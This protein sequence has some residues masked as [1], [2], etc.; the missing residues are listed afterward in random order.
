VGVAEVARAWTK[1]LDVLE[2][3]GFA[4]RAMTR[5]GASTEDLDRVIQVSGIALPDDMRALYRLSNGQ[6]E[7]WPRRQID[8]GVTTDLFPMYTFLSTEQA[9]TEWQGWKAIFDQEGPSGMADHAEFVIVPEPER[10]AKE[11]WHPGWWPLARDG[12]GNLLA[13]D[14]VPPPS[15]R[16]GQIIV[17]GSDEDVRR[18]FAPGIVA[19]LD[20]LSAAALEMHQRSGQV[21]WDIPALR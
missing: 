8:S 4:A 14:T 12:G 10:V 9:A 7:P 19:Y 18:V 20:A 15:G 16:V 2:A 5:Q 17:M 3:H 1:W 11:Y 13:V 21:F 6:H